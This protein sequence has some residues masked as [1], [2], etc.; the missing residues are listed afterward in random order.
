MEWFH[1]NEAE[2][3]GNITKLSLTLL[4]W[5]PGWDRAVAHGGFGAAGW[6]PVCHCAEQQ[7]V[8]GDCRRAVVE[9]PQQLLQ[10]RSVVSRKGPSPLE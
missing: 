4:G 1:P 8:R 6:G 9:S 5:G 7:W 10:L 3:N 2:R